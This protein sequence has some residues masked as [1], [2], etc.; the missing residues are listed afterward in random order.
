MKFQVDKKDF[1]KIIRK[2]NRRGTSMMHVLNCVLLK[3]QGKEVTITST[4]LGYFLTTTLPAEIIEEGAVLLPIKELVNVV[5]S[6]PAGEIAVEWDGGDFAKVGPVPIE[7][8]PPVEEFPGT[9]EP[10]TGPIYKV[11]PEVLKNALKKA[12]PIAKATKSGALSL[13]N[14]AFHKNQI[15]GC[16]GHRLV[17]VNMPFTLKGDK[18]FLLPIEEATKLSQVI[19]LVEGDIAFRV[20]GWKNQEDAPKPQ[21]LVEAQG[22]Q[23]WALGFEGCYPEYWRIFP[24]QG[25]EVVVDVES[26]KTAAEIVAGGVGKKDIFPL[27]FSVGNRKGLLAGTEKKVEADFKAMAPEKIKFVVNGVY[28][29]EAIKS[30]QS[31]KVN[32][33]FNGMDYPVV[34]IAS[35]LKHLLMPL[36]TDNEE[37]EDFPSISAENL[38]DIP[39]TLNG[40]EYQPKTKK[41]ASKPKGKSQVAKLKAEIK[42]LEAVV[43]KLQEAGLKERKAKEFWQEKALKLEEQVRNLLKELERLAR[44]TRK[45]LVKE[46]VPLVFDGSKALAELE[47][48]KIMLANGRIW[49]ESGEILGAYDSKTGFGFLAGS[50]ILVA[51]ENGGFILKPASIN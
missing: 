31:K 49:A 19:D 29:L 32:L 17:A 39:Q 26:L 46:P 30:F 16:D 9:P 34:M 50:P 11:S 48:H 14:I 23:F 4:T 38:V 43:K 35:G 41:R 22:F 2:H 42:E 3:V 40:P 21:I 36:S 1:D 20:V 8:G 6:L 10:L 18:F 7:V 44:K 13:E 15:L 45:V 12:L 24:T 25:L 5:K 33:Y 47:G 37:K 28:L 27:I 51:Q